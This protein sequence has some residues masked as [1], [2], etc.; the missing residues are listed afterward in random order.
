[1]RRNFQEKR[2]YE[3]TSETGDNP[4]KRQRRPSDL[5]IRGFA[6][7]SAAPETFVESSS[8]EPF[9]SIAWDFEDDE[10]S[11]LVTTSACAQKRRSRGLVR[12]LAFQT[13]PGVC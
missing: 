5:D 3:S 7:G 11:T 12:S 2:S 9:P 10:S 8:D 1:M 4:T 6:A 13:L